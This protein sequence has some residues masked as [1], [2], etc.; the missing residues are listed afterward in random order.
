MSCRRTYKSKGPRFLDVAAA[1]YE[2][3]RIRAGRCVHECNFPADS[4]RRFSVCMHTWR[5]RQTWFPKAK[6]QLRREVRKENTGETQR[7]EIQRARPSLA[8]DIRAHHSAEQT[9]DGSDKERVHIANKQIFSFFP[10][11]LRWLCDA[12]CWDKRRVA[13]PRTVV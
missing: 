4:F 12:P 6:R 5:C 13:S 10:L 11:R 8:E 3:R 1:G 7:R 2:D 9:A